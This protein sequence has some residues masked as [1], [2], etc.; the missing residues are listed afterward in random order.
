MASIEAHVLDVLG[1]SSE[2]GLSYE[3]ALGCTTWGSADLVDEIARRTRLTHDQASAAVREM[4]HEGL[5]QVT[6][7]GPDLLQVIPPTLALRPRLSDERAKLV[8]Q[9]QLLEAAGGRLANLQEAY[10]TAKDVRSAEVM[11]HVTGIDALRIRLQ[12]MAAATR[13]ETLSLLPVHVLNA[14][15]IEN[16]RRLDE[17]TLA[18]GVAVRTVVV[19]S[20]ARDRT[21]AP[22]LQWLVDNGAEIRT[23]P[24]LPLRLVV[25]DRMVA[26]LPIDSV[27]PR[28]GALV[29]RAPGLL[30]ALVA[31]F[32]LVWRTAR[33]LGAPRT[34]STLEIG[35]TDA[36]LLRVLATGATDESVSRHLGVSVRTVRRLV[37]A[38]MQQLG[39]GSRFELGLRLGARGWGTADLPFSVPGSVLAADAADFLD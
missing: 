34:A 32:E 10:A 3:V 31:L 35:E 8:A 17:E 27:T 36:E 19:E 26:I 29:L 39:A 9:Q 21:I 38:L 2:V 22:Y 20:A 11:E 4:R 18:R 12:E 33:P 6:E 16:S 1:V 7:S 25:S 14:Q 5:L 15:S 28:D 24:A 37:S 30:T 13:Q 23:A